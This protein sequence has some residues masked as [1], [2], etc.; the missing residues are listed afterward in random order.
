MVWALWPLT[1]FPVE[2]TTGT[3]TPCRLLAFNPTPRQRFA[4]G[5]ATWFRPSVP[6]T[7]VALTA[8]AAAAAE[9]KRHE[10]TKAPQEAATSRRFR[11]VNTLPPIVWTLT[12]HLRRARVVLGNEMRSA[13]TT[14][15]AGVEL[16]LASAVP[17]T[18]GQRPE[19]G[20]NTWTVAR[21]SRSRSQPVPIRRPYLTRRDR[22]RLRAGLGSRSS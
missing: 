11:K 10:A 16:V 21:P 1:T 7:F 19:N 8:T 17:H 20:G 6:A 5:H 12:L 2:G 22:S 15:S 9:A 14:G 3:A 18:S 13:L 4:D